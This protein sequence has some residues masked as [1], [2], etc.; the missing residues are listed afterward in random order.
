M[1]KFS[2]LPLLLATAVTTVLA[3]G[4]SIFNA[5]QTIQNATLKLQS[6]VGSWDGGLLGTLPIVAE[7]A[8]LLADIKKG[9]KVAE[10]SAPLSV[11]EAITVAQE[12]M[13]LA[14]GVNQTLTTIISAKPK[15]DRLLLVSPVILLNLEMEKS[16]TDDMSAAIID[17]VPADLQVTAKQLVAPI[18]DSFNEAIAVY[19]HGI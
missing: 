6:S 11:L 18:D 7:S 15:F 9:Q 4:A 8:Q 16:A 3:D 1:L 19:Q 13:A 12:T 14:T 10:Q 2:I 17:K 5:L